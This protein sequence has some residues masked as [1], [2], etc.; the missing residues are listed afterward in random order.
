MFD[1][2]KNFLN[3]FF[4]AVGGAHKGV[5]TILSAVKTPC[6][7]LAQWVEE[8]LSDD[9]MS[10]VILSL[11]TSSVGI[12]DPISRKLSALSPP[13]WNRP[14]ELQM[15]WWKLSYS[16][17]GTSSSSPC[18]SMS[19]VLSM[20]TGRRWSIGGSRVKVVCQKSEAGESLSWASCDDSCFCPECCGKT[21]VVVWFVAFPDRH[22]V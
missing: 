11:R 20:S 5:S 10:H 14:R 16:P 8:A 22:T 12:N 19:I 4:W 15:A 3:L 9:R 1:N 21:L 13:E 18:W 17:S 7:V 6:T 2:V